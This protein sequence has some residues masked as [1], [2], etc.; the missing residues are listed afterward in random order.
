MGEIR[1]TRL[2][3]GFR[4]LRATWL[5]LLALG[6]AGMVAPDPTWDPP[7]EAETASD[8]EPR[9]RVVLVWNGI[10]YVPIILVDP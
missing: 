10:V 8:D 1:A 6:F 2:H 5:V 4:T 7:A 9:V 3:R